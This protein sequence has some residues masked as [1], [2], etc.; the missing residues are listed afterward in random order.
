MLLKGEEILKA[1]KNKYF[2]GKNILSLIF[3]IY[4]LTILFFSLFSENTAYI[5]D[6]LLFITFLA[7]IYF[8]YHKLRFNLITL[9][10]SGLAMSLHLLGRF[11]F[12]QK[13]FFGLNYDVYTHFFASFALV[14][15]LY[16][17]LTPYINIKNKFLLFLILVVLNLGFATIGEF[18]EWGGTLYVVNGEGFIGLEAESN[19]NP[20]FSADYWDTMTD[21]ARNA[22]GAILG[23]I[24]LSLL[25]KKY[26]DY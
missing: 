13:Q 5:L 14:M 23:A 4:Y 8:F 25:P 16:F 15:V 22:L 2:N 9:F 3:M 20:K 11:G 10:F 7:I 12:F 24:F 26:F 21:L 18:I 17:Y 19:G 1:M 6:S